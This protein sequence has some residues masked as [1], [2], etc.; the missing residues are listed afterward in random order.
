[1]AS[2]ASP[3]RSIRSSGE[4][5]R[6]SVRRASLVMPSISPPDPDHSN[7]R[8]GR[9][10]PNTDLRFC[11]AAN[12]VTASEAR[13]PDAYRDSSNRLLESFPR[14]SYPGIIRT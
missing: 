10:R 4:R 1:M 8:M 12:V 13:D 3:S 5:R 14:E 6:I 2:Q 7:G 9:V 11:C